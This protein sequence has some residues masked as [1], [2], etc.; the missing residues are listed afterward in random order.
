VGDRQLERIQPDQKLTVRIRPVSASGKASQFR[1]DVLD[2]SLH[3]LLLT[4][5][6]GLVHDTLIDII[7]L[8]P[9]PIRARVVRQSELGTHLSFVDHL[10]PRYRGPGTAPTK[11]ER[12][13]ST[14]K[15]TKPGRKKPAGS[16]SKRK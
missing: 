11:S 13:V 12:D 4:A 3:G 6:P 16:K 7:G 2:L 10:H 8:E 9:K 5:I 1:A 15:T 14:K